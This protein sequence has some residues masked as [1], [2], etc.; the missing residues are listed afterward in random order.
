MKLTRSLIRMYPAP[1]R[2]RYGAAIEDEAAARGWRAWPNL[3][4][5]AVDMWL[6][7]SVWPAD[8]TA[9][10]LHRAITMAA[11]TAASSWYVGHL[12]TERANDVSLP[13]RAFTLCGLLMALGFALTVP[14]PRWNIAALAALVRLAAGRLV[15]PAAL[16][17]LVIAALQAHPHALFTDSGKRLL[18]A[19][20]WAAQGLFLVQ[21]CRFVAGLDEELTR[22]P[23]RRR[24]H[25]GMSVLAA[26]GLLA[27]GLLIGF[28]IRASDIQ[29][30]D[31]A[32]GLCLL[33]LT[34][35]PVVTA[36]DVRSLPVGE[37]R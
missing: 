23:S 8:S 19:L 12:V 22:P 28:A 32:G 9:Q 25:A 31:L 34:V 21:G 5:G 7:P 16:A 15:A 14:R 1:F 18:L 37:S 17:V 13:E 20:W 26:A 29:P 27:G 30:L 3:L 35:G 33:L 10:R 2:E 24:L 4:V 11:A 36:R 6:H